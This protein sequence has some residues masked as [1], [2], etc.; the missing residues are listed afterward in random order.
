VWWRVTVA[1]RNVGHLRNIVFFSSKLLAVE[2]KGRFG[3][4]S[5][6]NLPFSFLIGSLAMKWACNLI[7]ISLGT[8]NENLVHEYA[9]SC[10]SVV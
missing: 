6:C 7:M 1:P 3:T 10:H 4:H 9:D 2:H 5:L 8:V